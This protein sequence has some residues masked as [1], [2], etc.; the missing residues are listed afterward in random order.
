VVVAGVAPA[1]RAHALIE[2]AVL[3]TDA[4][5]KARAQT[6]APH[7]QS[8]THALGRAASHGARGVACRNSSR[9]VAMLAMRCIA[10]NRVARRNVRL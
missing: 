2:Q 4:D 7:A 5:A 6:Q 9:G 10:S 3:R 1:V 8:A